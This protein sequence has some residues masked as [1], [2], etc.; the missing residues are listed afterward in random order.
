ME[1]PILDLLIIWDVDGGFGLFGGWYI[2]M[3]YWMSKEETSYVR[4]SIADWSIEVKGICMRDTWSLV[5]K[6]NLK[7]CRVWSWKEVEIVL[8]SI[9]RTLINKLLEN[10]VSTKFLK[11]QGDRVVLELKESWSLSFSGNVVSSN[12]MLKEI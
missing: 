1:W 8:V 9:L 2:W 5:D 3:S 4:E 7:C 10:I 11:L 12:S 6:K